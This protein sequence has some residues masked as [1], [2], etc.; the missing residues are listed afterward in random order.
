MKGLKHLVECHCVLPQFRRR[1]EPPYH[2]FVVFSLF[3]DSDTA[4]P[5]HAKCNNCGVIHNVIDVCK[6][7]ILAG[8]EVGAIMTTEDCGTMLPAGIKQMLETYSCDVP[9]WEHALFILQ[10]EK[11]GD[12]IIIHREETEAGDLT[13]KILRFNGPGNYRLEPFLQKR[14]V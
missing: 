1:K 5:K 4:I 11:W 14:T 9:D 12:F 7:E 3:D 2:S 6:S 10:N 8:Q 13:G